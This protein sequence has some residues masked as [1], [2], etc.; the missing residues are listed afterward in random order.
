MVSPGCRRDQI[1][2]P[3]PPMVLGVPGIEC[4]ILRRLVDMVSPDF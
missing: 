3:D 2:R 1:Q 4:L